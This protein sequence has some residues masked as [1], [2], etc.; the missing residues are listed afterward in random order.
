MSQSQQAET[1]C[2]CLTHITRRWLEVNSSLSRPA[3]MDSARLE[4]WPDFENWR[5]PASMFT[6]TG[7]RQ[8]P[9]TWDR[10]EDLRMLRGPQT[11]VV[12]DMWSYGQPWGHHPIPLSSCA[13]DNVVVGCMSCEWEQ[14]RPGIDVAIPAPTPIRSDYL[15]PTDATEVRKRCLSTR[16]RSPI[17]RVAAVFRGSSR[18]KSTRLRLRL[19]S[20]DG[21]HVSDELGSIR[22]TLTD[23]RQ[24]TNV[25]SPSFEDGMR[26]AHFALAPRGDAHFTFRFFEA[27][28]AGLIPVVLSDSW[29]LPFAE[30]IDWSDVA[31]LVPEARLHGI[32]SI[33]ANMTLH[34]VCAMR[35][36]VHAV[37]EEYIKEPE[38]WAKAIETILQ[39]PR[40]P[41]NP[42]H[43]PVH[44]RGET[45]WNTSWARA[46][47]MPGEV[48]VPLAD[49]V[50][51]THRRYSSS[52]S[53]ASLQLEVA[54][55]RGWRGRTDL[56]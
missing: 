26:R 46:A 6:P 37:Y 56:A 41:P 22:V 38:R 16:K 40:R 25:N 29:A 50:D 24:P 43:R 30:L 12:L 32:P 23:R 2:S 49:A 53:S 51:A 11:W 52:R 3:C 4:N 20:L 8:S 7:C 27:M 54:R 34:Q 9:L 14:L 19:T 1:R 21:A 48:A 17:E 36:R 55:G 13:P 44:R 35:M 45:G 5:R 10:C 18:S 28:A 39:R 47:T 15:F 31:I 42:S 33:L